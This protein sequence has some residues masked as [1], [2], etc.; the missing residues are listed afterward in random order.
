VALLVAAW[1]LWRGGRFLPLTWRT[2]ITLLPVLAM[3]VP[4]P[5]SAV[6]DSLA[7]AWIVA[8]FDGLV[9][10]DGTFWR[11]GKAVLF[12]ALFSLLPVL[13]VAWIQRKRRNK[14][15]QQAIAE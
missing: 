14:Q 4:A 1:V 8:L 5:V 3:L 11:A 9:Q 12:A 10:E 15:T 7:P 2:L 6:H 13:L